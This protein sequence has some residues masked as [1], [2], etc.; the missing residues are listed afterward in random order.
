MILVTSRAITAAV[1]AT[2]SADQF[3]PLPPQPDDVAVLVSDDPEAV[4]LEPRGS[5]LEPVGT[6]RE[7]TGLQGGDARR[8]APVPGRTH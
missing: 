8:L 3:R 6:F 5:H 7:R 2:I 4:V 1:I